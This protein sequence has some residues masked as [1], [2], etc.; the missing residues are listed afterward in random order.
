MTPLE[1][2][3]SNKPDLYGIA[4]SQL[5]DMLWDQL[6][7]DKYEDESIFREYLTTDTELFD[8]SRLQT[9]TPTIESEQPELLEEKVNGEDRN[10]FL[11]LNYYKSLMEAVP[12]GF[13]HTFGTWMKGQAAK[14]YLSEMSP[15]AQKL[16]IESPWWREQLGLEEGEE[17][18]FSKIPDPTMIPYLDVVKKTLGISKADETQDEYLR[19]EYLRNRSNEILKNQE[20]YAPDSIEWA[21]EAKNYLDEKKEAI[22]PIRERELWKA[23][24]ALNQWAEK[25]FQLD[26]EYYR[27]DEMANLFLR[28]FEVLG[29]SLGF[30]PSYAVGTAM[31]GPVGGWLVGLDFAG[32]VGMGEQV[33]MAF[34]RKPEL[35]DDIAAVAA[36]LG[37]APGAVD[38]V[39]VGRMMTLLDRMVPGSSGR[40]RNFLTQGLITGTYEATLEEGQNVLH[41]VIAQLLYNADQDTLEGLGEAFGPG[42]IAGF[43]MGGAGGA[44]QPVNRIEKEKEKIIEKEIGEKPTEE[45][46][47]KAQEGSPD[48]VKKDFS[49]DGSPPIGA[50]VSVSEAGVN[51]GNGK[52]ISYDRDIEDDTLNVKIQPDDGTA[53][54][55]R[56][57][58]DLDIVWL[59]KPDVKE[60]VIP[61][62]TVAEEEVTPIVPEEVTPTEV[63]EEEIRPSAIMSQEDYNKLEKQWNDLPVG[64][65]LRFDDVYYQKTKINEPLPEEIQP[66]AIQLPTEEEVAPVE[67][68]V[69]PVEE[70][71]EDLDRVGKKINLDKE[72]T[73]GTITGV[74]TQLGE[75]DN[76]DD[77]TK[78]QVTR[79][80]GVEG[81]I[82]KTKVKEF[83]DDLKVT[84]EDVKPKVKVLTDNIKTVGNWN[85]VFEAN[86][87]NKEVID[88]LTKFDLEGLINKETKPAVLRVVRG[89][90]E[91]GKFK[92]KAVQKNLIAVNKRISEL[93]GEPVEEVAPIVKPVEEKKPKEFIDKILTSEEVEEKVEEKVEKTTG[94]EELAAMTNEQISSM[95]DDIASGIEVKEE[96]QVEKKVVEEK[97]KE[98]KKEA[99]KVVEAP[100]EVKV[101]GYTKPIK[102]IGQWNIRASSKSDIVHAKKG[103]VTSRKDA[104]ET[105]LDLI[106]AD[107]SGLINKENSVGLLN[108]T[109]GV[110]EKNKHIDYSK[111]GL[112]QYF[113]GTEGITP[114]N[115]ESNLEAV[116]SRIAEIKGEKKPVIKEE[117]KVEDEELLDIPTTLK[118]G[119]KVRDLEAQ[120]E[121]TKGEEQTKIIKEL[122]RLYKERGFPGKFATEDYYAKVK[123]KPK[124]P[125]PLD[126]DYKPTLIREIEYSDLY[127]KFGITEFI[128]DIGGKIRKAE[129]IKDDAYTIDYFNDLT[130]TPNDVVD[131]LV[132]NAEKNNLQK[133]LKKY[134]SLIKK[135][136]SD[137]EAN[138]RVEQIAVDETELEGKTEKELFAEKKLEEKPKV[139]EK[140]K[141]IKFKGRT[142]NVPLDHEEQV[143]LIETGKNKNWAD[144]WEKLAELNPKSEKE[145]DDAAARR[146]MNFFDSQVKVPK[147]EEEFPTKE[148]LQ[149]RK[150][151][152]FSLS[153]TKPA[154]TPD[155]KTTIDY[156]TEIVPL[157][158]LITSDNKKEFPKELQPR[159]RQDNVNSDLQAQRIAKEPK[160]DWL[161]EENRTDQ[162][163]PLIGPDNIVESGNGRVMG[164][165]LSSKQFPTEFQ[166][167]LRDISVDIGLDTTEQKKIAGILE[168]KFNE[169][170]PA[171]VVRR[172]VTPFSDFE[173][174]KKFT[175]DS[176]SSSLLEKS[177]AEQAKID[178]S[179]MPEG[180][181]DKYEGGSI[182]L[183]KNRDFVNGFHNI[184]PENEQ[185]EIIDNAGDLTKSGVRRIENA[186]IIKAFG[187]ISLFNR[188]AESAVPEVKAL[189]ESFLMAAPRWIKL[190]ESIESG[191]IP[192]EFD[193]TYHVIDSLN[194]IREARKKKMP[195]D[196]FLNQGSLLETGEI[197]PYTKMLST[198]FYRGKNYKNLETADNIA[199]VLSQ[200]ADSSRNFKDLFLGDQTPAQILERSILDVKKDILPITEEELNG[201][202]TEAEQTSPTRPES[203][204]VFL[205]E[206]GERKIDLGNIRETGDSLRAGVP[207]VAERSSPEL[208]REERERLGESSERITERGTGPINRL[209][210]EQESRES[211]R[212]PDTAQPEQL[213]EFTSGAE[214]GKVSNT[215]EARQ[216]SE[217]DLQY[218]QLAGVAARKLSQILDKITIKTK[219][220]T[221]KLTRLEK[222]NVGDALTLSRESY[223]E[224]F[225]DSG[226]GGIV[227]IKGRVNFTVPDFVKN[228]E[229]TI[230]ELTLPSELARARDDVIKKIEVDEGVP[231]DK[232]EKFTVSNWI[233]IFNERLP[234]DNNFTREYLHAN[235]VNTVLNNKFSHLPNPRKYL[236]QKSADSMKNLIKA[237][238]EII[239]EFKRKPPGAIGADVSPHVKNKDYK[240]AKPYF[241]K[242]WAD[243]KDAGIGIQAWT[244]QTIEALKRTFG[245][246]KEHLR[247]AIEHLKRFI[248]SLRQGSLT[249]TTKEGEQSKYQLKHNPISKAPKMDTFTPIDLDSPLGRGMES[250]L[251]R[252]GDIDRFVTT[253]LDYKDENEMTNS[254]GGEQVEAVAL[255]IDQLDSGRGFILGDQTGVGKGRVVAAMLRWSKL[256]GKNA[257][258]VTQKPTLYADMIR[259]LNDIGENIKDLKILPTNN[260]LNID[261]SD[262]P[263][264]GEVVTPKKK[265]HEK[266]LDRLTQLGNMEEY[267]YVFTTY[268]QMNRVGGRID[269]RHQFLETIAENSIFI[270]DE[271]HTGGGQGISNL[272][273]LPEDKVG[274]TRAD[275]LRDLLRRSQGA[276]YSSATW[277][278]HPKVMDLYMNTDIQDSIPD[279]EEFIDTMIKGGLP[280]QSTVSNM[281][282]ET[283]QYRR[284]EKSFQGISFNTVEIDIDKKGFTET[285]NNL[286]SV[287]QD[288]VS[289]DRK[290]SA[291]AKRLTSIDPDLQE[292]RQAGAKVNVIPTN[293]RSQM[294]YISGQLMTAMKIKEVAEMAIKEHKAGRKPMIVLS[295]TMEAFLREYV[296]DNNLKSGDSINITYNDL[297]IRYLNRTK[298]FKVKINKQK[299][300]KIATH[301]AKIVNLDPVFTL[302]NSIIEQISEELGYGDIIGEFSELEHKIKSLDFKDLSV[303]PI[304][305]LVTILEDAGIKVKEL[306][307]RGM[308]ITKDNKLKSR[309]SSPSVIRNGVND[310]NAGNID[311]LVM[312]RT[313]GTGLSMHAGKD[314]ADQKIRHMIVLEAEP[315]VTDF[316]QILG[317][318]NRTGQEDRVPQYSLFSTSHPA[319]KRIAAMLERKMSTLNASTSGSI[320]NDYSVKGIVDFMNSAGDKAVR[321]FLQSNASMRSLFVEEGKELEEIIGIAEQ[322]ARGLLIVDP[323]TANKFYDFL[324]KRY[325]EIK[326]EETGLGINKTHIVLMPDAQAVTTEQQEIHDG[327]PDGSPFQKP[328]YLDKIT[329]KAS[330][331][332]TTA[333]LRKKIQDAL[334]GKSVQQFTASELAETK[335]IF[336][337]AANEVQTKF[338]TE[339][340]DI[341]DPKKKT[342]KEHRS[343][344]EIQ[345]LR[346]LW[347]AIESHITKY[348]IGS[349]VQIRVGKEE[350]SP[351]YDGMVI[352]R[353]RDTSKNPATAGAM[354][355]TLALANGE[356]QQVT[357]ALS[358]FVKND[359]TSGESILRSVESSKVEELFTS[360][361]QAVTEER[362]LITGNLLLGSSLIKGGNF[363]NIQKRVGDT[364]E[365]NQFIGILMPKTFN[366]EKAIKNMPVKFGSEEEIY[367]YFV[368]GGRNARVKNY[369]GDIEILASPSVP[370]L[371]FI[372]VKKGTKLVLEN[373]DLTD[374]LQNG[375]KKVTQG[376]FNFVGRISLVE[377]RPNRSSLYDVLQ[378]LHELGIK[379]QTVTNRE[380]AQ[381]AKDNVRPNNAG[382]GGASIGAMK[383]PKDI[384]DSIKD[385]TNISRN[386]LFKRIRNSMTSMAR[387]VN[388]RY[389]ARK[390]PRVGETRQFYSR[391]NEHADNIIM[392]EVNENIHIEKGIFPAITAGMLQKVLPPFVVAKRFIDKTIYN[393]VKKSIFAQMLERKM[394]NRLYSGKY[395]YLD[396]IKKYKKADF[397]KVVDVMWTGDA[398]GRKF[399]AK[400][401]KEGFIYTKEEKAELKR[402]GHSAKEINRA[403]KESKFTDDEVAFYFDFYKSMERTVRMVDKYNLSMVPLIRRMK[404]LRKKQVEAQVNPEFIKDLRTLFARKFLLEKQFRNNIGNPESIR[405]EIQSIDEQILSIPLT[406]YSD[407]A[408]DNFNDSVAQYV[409]EERKL[410]GISLRGKKVGYIPHIFFGSF[411]LKVFKGTDK[412]S[413]QEIWEDLIVPETSKDLAKKLKA[414]GR[415]EEQ[416]Q[417]VI[418]D[419]ESSKHTLFFNTKEEALKAAQRY[420]KEH[421]TDTVKI[422]P[423]N[424]K[425]MSDDRTVLNDREYRNI[426][427]GITSS[428]AEELT[429]EDVAVVGEK[430]RETMKRKSR[431][432]I[433]TFSMKRKGIPGY[434]KNLHKVMRHFT[435]SVAHYRYMD[436]LKYEYIGLMEKKGW[437]EVSEIKDPTGRKIAEWLETYWRDL[438]RQT[439]T[440]EAWVDWAL[441]EVQKTFAGNPKLW[442]TLAIST[443][444][445]AIGTGATLGT[446]ALG[447]L[448]GYLMYRAM[449]TQQFKSRAVTGEM[450]SITAHMKLGAFTNL[451]SAF[452]NLT[453]LANAYIK[454]GASNITVGL[455]R[456][457]ASL[458]RMAR[459]DYNTILENPEKYSASK[460]NAA[461]DA[462][463]L[464]KYAD[465]KSEYFYTDENPDVFT[466]RSRLGEFSMMWFQGAETI[467]RATSFLTG[468]Y[469]A[470]KEGKNRAQ[471]IKAGQFAIFQEQF[472]YDNSAKPELLRSTL[473]RV[474]LQFKNW[475]MQ[476][477]TFTFGLR[478]WEW[479]R[480]MAIYFL[481]AG[482]LGNIFLAFLDGAMRLFGFSP[483]Q[484]IKE[485]SVEMAGK[486]ETEAM[487]GQIIAHGLPSVVSSTG[488]GPG[489]NLSARV[490]LS[491]KGLPTE[492][493][494]FQGPLLSTFL[495]MYKLSSEGA[496]IGDQIVN[497]TPAG[498][499]FK[500][501]EAMAGGM[502][503]ESVF[504]DF[505]EFSQ[506]FMANWRDEQEATVVDPYRNRNIK[507]EG[508]SDGDLLRMMLG[509]QTTKEA[510]ISDFVGGV[511]RQNELRADE[512]NFV[513][514]RINNAVRKYKNNPNKLGTELKKIIEE[515]MEDGVNIT[516]QGIKRMIIDAHLSLMDREFKNAPKSQKEWILNNI[517]NM[518]NQY[519]S[520]AIGSYI[521]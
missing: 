352:N 365:F 134:E 411:R 86:K 379:F 174:R 247:I 152:I 96:A 466:E 74:M 185:G 390:N 376:E 235:I 471:S 186:L 453:Q 105:L 274:L 34:A 156:K 412:E 240:K 10:P 232:S 49:P 37:W 449:K 64:E 48:E 462:M 119:K 167:Y 111:T 353:K 428:L 125:E 14:Q 89:K 504:T 426:M 367:Q 317:R 516:Y 121:K 358:R 99:E 502:P 4:E 520:D 339:T 109:K 306:T 165:R 153:G 23:G 177:S 429:L 272:S 434:E 364:A 444:V 307:G 237:F 395:G 214:R 473:L 46:K 344:K 188:I 499:V 3:R 261:V 342:E 354:Q 383:T 221:R 416:I 304:D 219:E 200:Y 461:K 175:Q 489:I 160:A 31:A 95:I 254:L 222:E 114:K 122:N 374:R 507:I 112:S 403:E 369:R 72:G 480:F 61:V 402:Q 171:I 418:N 311:A 301:N 75:F 267:D 50:K 198:I 506:N 93:K 226:V 351:V 320:K 467:N 133:D 413:G 361:Q 68:E 201:Y 477:L 387:S 100:A 334:D 136:R 5:T 385:E 269:V 162:G 407:A 90:L 148:E 435:A 443:P 366:A 492:L 192:K 163:A 288:L 512:M 427:Q 300:S 450:L 220:G 205:G 388:E 262:V 15:D 22:V 393:F 245:K 193:L 459:R 243:A 187:D 275:F 284:L 419:L 327:L 496:S 41:N 396:V 43:M 141:Q 183:E 246:I 36:K 294:H 423:V 318:I 350:E 8:K 20:N 123:E 91:K 305:D 360:G 513:K 384:L 110:L 514:T 180:L 464:A 430:A 490:G 446:A 11:E 83:N 234:E 117:P 209:A 176:N 474:P 113:P 417:N 212:R 268:D 498:K 424:I 139:E 55:D 266:E 421:P 326:E 115:V 377:N 178:V 264:F 472:S 508:F 145:S 436:E 451:S 52:I 30:I 157:S 208:S 18:D 475:M 386:S 57:V 76:I 257:V 217:R 70:E 107:I 204:A 158:Q 468:F 438:N 336:E 58:D 230:E 280:L 227:D 130:Q 521:D 286:S 392:P 397:H 127:D 347:N 236:L 439:Q 1:Q 21:K 445:V 103:N 38:F 40:F 343:A 382:E 35:E 338:R 142:Y 59:N 53:P 440:G 51:L 108:V 77:A 505:P 455:N 487:V 223:V 279:A 106:N 314:F 196:N 454:H 92:N 44:I 28:G 207:D 258:F 465:V 104:Y 202:R 67:E 325:P 277:A 291:I 356:T 126:E 422:A 39:P 60:E 293:F 460:V 98:I 329:M 79:E 150:K 140:T 179:R 321:E 457:R 241:E 315:N 285:A 84:T 65:G 345:R 298:K 19:N 213:D 415:T 302:N 420:I 260:G 203:D 299:I 448:T 218:Y 197:H 169:G 194:Q 242:S 476:Q 24:E 26:D 346:T 265:E 495:N 348:P 337:E 316:V 278:K 6:G 335:R 486:G 249:N 252:R 81:T 206:E 398:A 244:R 357:V 144:Y 408:I 78:F 211:G 271:S 184:V 324:L 191:L 248:Q 283:G 296:A 515:A 71:V 491:D 172:R 45:Q 484:Y 131:V 456:A 478:G 69:V 224:K 488:V 394:A 389:S 410:I 312:N 190:R 441:D 431:R 63:A 363:V 255:A 371:A 310:F 164:L 519:G 239:E 181:I 517:Q 355:V 168:K 16:A 328:V 340:E 199:K 292:A 319:E 253:E 129:E 250:L 82:T 132:F 159:D 225:T 120:A 259:D 149:L 405:Q 297:L 281:L 56:P 210:R 161:G 341:T 510:Q 368:E 87:D 94:V 32:T 406:R 381:S 362:H 101:E 404:A 333:Q 80:D 135:I 116:N 215:T 282:A 182:A 47:E 447:G 332:Y 290:L 54:I 308:I 372:R 370:D 303:K 373:K 432:R 62:E 309:V 146:F 463:I 256:R 147:E 509:F 102:N 17:Y 511:K 399:T 128:N 322:V 12:R 313:A 501:V 469:Q 409:L 330:K 143:R 470:E 9:I 138:E 295:R 287:Y 482:A 238:Q 13:T 452:V 359:G 137:P 433:P 500:A 497:I 503:L 118:L 231:F 7:K 216:Q 375:W 485:W 481:L 27:E 458:Y 170:D 442:A 85:N 97:V 251:K 228:F 173:A 425:Y 270:L 124:A 391:T 323:A 414:Q 483:M 437:G 233:D 380:A 378:H 29:G 401:L 493:R 518:E 88:Q 189:S 66:V 2:L 166:K 400:E 155:N 494:D 479:P 276:M 25:K 273:G 331:P 229:L 289:L 349:T 42:F 263:E 73:K 195:F 154:T 33:E 151:P